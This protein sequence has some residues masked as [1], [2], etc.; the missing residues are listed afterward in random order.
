MNGNELFYNYQV[1]NQAIVVPETVDAIR[2]LTGAV[3]DGCA[4]I[5][6][7]DKAL[8]L[9]DSFLNDEAVPA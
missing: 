9:V 3:Q 7:T 1:N 2:A 5:A 4:S 8:G 6:M